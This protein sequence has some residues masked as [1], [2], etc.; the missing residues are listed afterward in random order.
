MY[1][2]AFFLNVT[3]FQLL[4]LKNKQGKVVNRFFA[5]V[6]VMYVLHLNLMINHRI[7]IYENFLSENGQSV[8]IRLRRIYFMIYL[9]YPYCNY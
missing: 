2:T 3:D 9:L 5:R 4:Y 7:F 6:T 1:L 8:Y